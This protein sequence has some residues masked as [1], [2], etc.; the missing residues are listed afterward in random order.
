M[1]GRP[2]AR[3]SVVAVVTKSHLA[4]IPPFRP[5]LASCSALTGGSVVVL[6]DGAEP[7]VDVPGVAWR[8][9]PA[10]D[11]PA[12][13]A[14]AAAEYTVVFV[15]ASSASDPVVPAADRVIVAGAG[16]RPRVGLSPADRVHV[17]RWKDPPDAVQR[18]ARTI[19]GRRVGLVLGAGGVRGFAHAGVLEVLDAER[20]PIDV[21]AGASVGAI[22]AALYLAGMPPS[23][24]ADL[25]RVVGDA[26][27]LALPG[28]GISTGSLWSGRRL[29][30][31][32]RAKLG[33]LRFEDLPIP[34]A[35]VTAEAGS[36]REIVL[37]S[38]S[39]A[40]AVFAS[41][42]L[43]GLYPPATVGRRRLIDGGVVN[44]V[45]N[46]AV[47]E[48]GAG[49][50]AAVNVMARPGTG[51]VWH[52]PGVPVLGE[53]LNTIPSFFAWV[54]SAARAV[55]DEMASLDLRGADVLIEPRFGHRHPWSLLPAAAFR[56]AGAEAAAA[57]VPQI[58]E[59]LRPSGRG[60]TTALTAVRS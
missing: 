22:A 10:A 42:A 36:R 30:R 25:R 13:A 27:R 37:D 4:A 46:S 32:L 49:I 1:N 58:Q 20:I 26:L 14:R 50:V 11:R 48:R 29:R 24:I 18:L 8:Q 5:L 38:G 60:Q 17:L 2:L 55:R 16:V 35:I 7:G 6:A 53:A 59:L 51:T 47:I 40:D 56:R 52:V 9:V 19:A 15:V 43:P 54:R 45:P 23:E 33:D 44:P 39:L 28:L 3:R 57:A 12:A 31:Y 21:M 34:L 41:S